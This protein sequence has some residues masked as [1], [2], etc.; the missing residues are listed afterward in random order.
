VL[1]LLE[2]YLTTPTKV[3][4]RPLTLS[5]QSSFKIFFSRFRS[6]HTSKPSRRQQ[7]PRVTSQYRLLDNSWV[8]QLW[9]TWCN[10]QWCSQSHKICNPRQ[11]MWE[12]CGGGHKYVKEPF[13]MAIEPPR[14]EGTGI[15]SPNSKTSHY[16]LPHKHRFWGLSSIRILDRLLFNPMAI[17]EISVC[18]NLEPLRAPTIVIVSY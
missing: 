16:S 6:L 9:N 5:S 14:G 2:L 7:H 18:Q 8:P 11:Y 3:C 15:Y 1:D 10:A 17:V 12:K 4:T 13:Q